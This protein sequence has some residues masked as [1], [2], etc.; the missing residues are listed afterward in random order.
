MVGL[1]LLPCSLLLTRKHVITFAFSV[2]VSYSSLCNKKNFK[3]CVFSVSLT[4]MDKKHILE[5]SF[6]C[7]KWHRRSYAHS[8]LTIFFC[9]IL[10]ILEITSVDVGVVAIKG[11]NSNYYLAIS[12]KGELYGAV[13]IRVRGQSGFSRDRDSVRFLCPYQSPVLIITS[14]TAGSTLNHNQASARTWTT[15]RTV[16]FPKCTLVSAQAHK[17]KH[18]MQI[19]E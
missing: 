14:L 11:L 18:A 2:P 15:R 17:A 9:W 3:S 6:H 4:Q 12:R 8:E 5:K 13:S 16:Q 7:H 10:G 19:K 1:R